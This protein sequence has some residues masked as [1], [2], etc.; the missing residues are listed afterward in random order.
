MKRHLIVEM[1]DR[2]LW[3]V[4]VMVIARNRAAV[5]AKEFGGDVERSLNEDTIPLFE[6]DDYNIEDWAT[7]NM[8]WSDV[9]GHATRLPSPPM[10]FNWELGWMNGPKSFSP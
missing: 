8:N 3:A 10:E 7:G 2:S 6:E 1:P 4:P 9:K 5:Y